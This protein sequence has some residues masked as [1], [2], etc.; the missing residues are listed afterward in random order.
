M[1]DLDCCF[2]CGTRV[3][4]KNDSGWKVMGYALCIACDKACKYTEK[5]NACLKDYQKCPAN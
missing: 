5:G 4:E 1:F 3:T 2:E